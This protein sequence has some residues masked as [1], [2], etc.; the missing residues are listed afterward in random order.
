MANEMEMHSASASPK[1]PPAFAVHDFSAFQLFSHCQSNDRF[2]CGS[3]S[4]D[5]SI[6]RHSFVIYLFVYCGSTGCYLWFCLFCL[7]VRLV[8]SF[9]SA[10]LCGRIP[11]L[12]PGQRN[13]CREMPDALI[14][15][16]EGHQLGAQECQ[17]QFRGHRW[18]CSEVW[19]RNVFAHVIPTG[20]CRCL[21][22]IPFPIPVPSRN[23]RPRRELNKIIYILLVIYDFM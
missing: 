12:T 4:I 3:P 21:I 11:G 23:K 5:R 9:T 17:H 19:Q 7:L 14:A 15:L 22:P 20:E 10:M 2:G 13:M 18:N 1:E 16:G 6:D 8:S